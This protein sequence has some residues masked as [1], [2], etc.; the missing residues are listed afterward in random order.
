MLRLPSVQNAT[1]AMSELQS[2]GI[3]LLS[4]WQWRVAGT[5]AEAPIVRMAALDFLHIAPGPC[6]LRIAWSLITKYLPTTSPHR[7]FAV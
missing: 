2:T 1:W 7:L 3:A 6:D 5:V 4:S